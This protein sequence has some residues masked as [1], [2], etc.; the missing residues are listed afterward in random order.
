MH[1]IQT[2]LYNSSI[3]RIRHSTLHRSSHSTRI[4][5]PVSPESLDPCLR[6]LSTGVSGRPAAR[7]HRLHDAAGLVITTSTVSPLQ[8]SASLYSHRDYR[9]PAN[10]WKSR[11]EAA[12]GPEML[13]P[14]MLPRY[15]FVMHSDASELQLTEGVTRLLPWTSGVSG[16]YLGSLL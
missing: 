5:R 8:Q 4:A 7:T 14:V 6:N 3:L 10:V 15:F 12:A 9:G 1:P 13:V 11:Y 2:I 16:R